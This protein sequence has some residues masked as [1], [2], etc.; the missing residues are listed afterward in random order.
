MRFHRL[1]LCV[2]LLL[3]LLADHF[4]LRL[5]LPL[6]LVGLR[7]ILHLHLLGLR[8]RL[9]LGLFALLIGLE[10]HLLNLQLRRRTWLRQWLA[11]R[12][13]DEV[14]NILLPAQLHQFRKR[15]VDVIG[16]NHDLAEW[17]LSKSH[18]PL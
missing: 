3:R 8:L 4:K 5:Q 18:L 10:L 13:A 6:H 12:V 2:G 1:A 16:R 11:L 15:V 9:Q 14:A 7:L 17:A